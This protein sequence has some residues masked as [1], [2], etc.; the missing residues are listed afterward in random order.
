MNNQK[1]KDLIV[2]LK[3]FVDTQYFSDDNDEKMIR[4]VLAVLMEL[5]S[6][7]KITQA[8]L[9]GIESA[10]SDYVHRQQLIELLKSKGL[11]AQNKVVTI[12]WKWIVRDSSVDGGRYGESAD[13]YTED[14]VKV[15]FHH[16]RSYKMDDMMRE[17]V[18]YV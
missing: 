12:R 13:Y 15:A 4:N 10:H 14:E 11:Y 18:E 3:E 9:V 5:E 16:N 7:G 1:I 17:D 8:D 2:G 6:I